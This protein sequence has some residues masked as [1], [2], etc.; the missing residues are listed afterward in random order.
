MLWT[1][2]HAR[3]LGLAFERVL[4]KSNRGSMA[5]VRCLTPE[6]CTQRA[7]RAEFQFS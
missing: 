6:L 3:I 1:N 2:L 5:F 7:S 4:G